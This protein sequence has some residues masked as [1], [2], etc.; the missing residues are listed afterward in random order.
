MAQTC[1]S[2]PSTTLR[3]VPLP[4]SF[5]AGRIIGSDRPGSS[6]RR[7]NPASPPTSSRGPGEVLAAL[8]RLDGALDIGLLVAMD[9]VEVAVRAWIWAAGSRSSSFPALNRRRPRRVSKKIRG[10]QIFCGTAEPARAFL[11]VQFG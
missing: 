1:S 7:H 3:V 6:R 8:P 5:L 4:T 10:T 11:V 9:P 2:Y